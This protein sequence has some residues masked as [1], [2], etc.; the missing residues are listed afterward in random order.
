MDSSSE[1]KMAVNNTYA[2]IINEIQLSKLN[3]SIQ[4]TPFA[5]Y[6]TLKKSVQKDINGVPATP[7]PPLL[8]LLQQAHQQVLYLQNE[9]AKIKL[10][11]DILEKKLEDIVMENKHL[12]NS[13]KNTNETISVLNDTKDMLHQK[14]NNA[15]NSYANLKNKNEAN[16]FKIKELK[17]NHTEEVKKLDI[18]IKDLVRE[19]KQNDKEKHDLNK[20]LGNT[21]DALKNSKVEKSK[22]KMPHKAG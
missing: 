11:T 10:N 22:L 7:S 3:F 6:I 21:R 5:S 15:E 1:L 14:L 13:L 4:M 20:I 19:K 2:A 17:K 9:N 18:Q 8:V 16:E 12:V